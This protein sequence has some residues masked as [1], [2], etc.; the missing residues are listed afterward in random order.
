[1]LKFKIFVN[2][3]SFS[4]L[5]FRP[6]MC[7]SRDLLYGFFLNFAAWLATISWE[8]SLKQNFQK[9]LLFGQIRNYGT[10]VAQNYGGFYLRIPSVDFPETCSMIDRSVN[11]THTIDRA[12]N[13]TNFSEN[14]TSK[15]FFL[16]LKTQRRLALKFLCESSLLLGMALPV[17]STSVRPILQW[18]W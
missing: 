9:S 6:K 4:C 3:E 10:I 16:F 2:C 1:M 15:K 13:I 18:N 11:E 14:R 12:G 17:P 8:K 5:I 7:L